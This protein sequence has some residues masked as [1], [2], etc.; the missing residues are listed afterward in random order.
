MIGNLKPKISFLLPL[1]LALL[2]MA[3]ITGPFLSEL[4][5]IIISIYGVWK[6]KEINYSVGAHVC[7]PVGEVKLYQADGLK[8]LHYKFLGIKLHLY[9]QKLRAD[10]LSDF[11]KKH[12]LTLYVLMN[13]SEHTEDYKNYFNRRKKVL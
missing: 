2:P 5:V 7:N 6:I 4:I 13:E 3:L 11:N 10:R 1:L 8:M 9:K 12:G